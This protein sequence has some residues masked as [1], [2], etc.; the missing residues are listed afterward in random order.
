MS[1]DQLPRLKSLVREWF[2]Y[3]GGMRGALMIFPEF[4]KVGATA[5]M[6]NQGCPGRTDDSAIWQFQADASARA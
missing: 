3:G 4:E 5:F 1:V 6:N 2:A